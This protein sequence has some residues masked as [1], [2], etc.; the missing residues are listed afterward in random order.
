MRQIDSFKRLNGL[1]KDSFTGIYRKH[2]TGDKYIQSL[3]SNLND[4]IKK[5]GD[6]EATPDNLE[7]MWNELSTEFETTNILHK[8][9]D[10]YR[11]IEKAVYSIADKISGKTEKTAKTHTEIKNSGFIDLDLF[12]MLSEILQISTV[13]TEMD[14]KDLIDGLHSGL[15]Q[16]LMK[17]RDTYEKNREESFFKTDQEVRYNKTADDTDDLPF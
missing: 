1:I 12:Q 3:H 16:T 14:S 4:I 5:Y 8:E 17:A 15:Y 6:E 2:T 9:Y 13:M 10:A 11:D 7:K